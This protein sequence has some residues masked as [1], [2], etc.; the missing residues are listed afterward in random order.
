MKKI[1]ATMIIEI[2]GRPAGH[3]TAALQQLI[4]ERLAKEQ[5]IRIIEKT[6]H[7]AVKVKDTKNLFSSFAELS[8]D[9]DD[10]TTFFGML[11]AYMPAH[12][13]LIT[14]EMIELSNTEMNQFANRLMHRLHD[15]DAIAKNIIAE[16][17][18]LVR[19]LN[20]VAP[21]TLRALQQPQQ[22]PSPKKKTKKK[23]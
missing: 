15:Y 18:I 22:T 21:D 9:I 17:D 3:I 6:V 5:G 19:K 12:V 10:L 7:Q 11:F 8:L 23:K 1:R 20:E 4:D 13:E 16:R 2:L 14:P